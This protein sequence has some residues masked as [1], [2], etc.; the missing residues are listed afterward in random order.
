MKPEFQ[1]EQRE[2]RTEEYQLLRNTTNWRQI[3]NDHVSKALKKDLFSVC[4]LKNDK[5]VGM[6]RVIGDGVI[7]FYIQDVIVLPEFRNRGVGQLIMNQ[8]ESYL[9]QMAP[10]DAFVGLMAAEGTEGFYRKFGYQRR[11]KN[12]PG[13]FKNLNRKAPGP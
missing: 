12:G 8:I 1:V 7:Y 2:I 10:E 6:G 11:P 5:I 13:M 4:I 3:P 9:D